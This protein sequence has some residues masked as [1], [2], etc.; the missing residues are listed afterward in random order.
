MDELTAAPQLEQ[1]NHRAR[2]G[3]EGEGGS[4]S[5]K[6]DAGWELIMNTNIGL[7]RYC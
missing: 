2:E 3:A 7:P 6:Q 5:G 1:A 4:S